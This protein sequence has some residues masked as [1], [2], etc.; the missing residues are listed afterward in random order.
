MADISFCSLFIWL[1]F[2]S[3]EV[4]LFMLFVITLFQGREA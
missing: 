3:N 4:I 2:E 1:W